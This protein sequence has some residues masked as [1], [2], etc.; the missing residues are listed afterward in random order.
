MLE[1]T[2]KL[3]PKGYESFKTAMIRAAEDDEL[4]VCLR[5]RDIGNFSLKDVQDTFSDIN[6]ETGLNV[7]G[8]LVLNPTDRRLDLFMHVSQPDSLEKPL[9]Q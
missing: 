4:P 5:L 6:L 9:L 1:G 8:S 3:F 7:R 2:K